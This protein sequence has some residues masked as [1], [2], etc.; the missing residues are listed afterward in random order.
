ML[1]RLK[2]HPTVLLMAA[3]HVM[4]DGYGNILAPLLPLLIVRLDLSL[5]A[6]GTLTMLY[7][8]AASVSQIGFGQLADRWRPRLLVI[9]GPVL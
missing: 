8:L 5:A 7:Q 2:L 9:A 4:V 1:A 6:A 3:A